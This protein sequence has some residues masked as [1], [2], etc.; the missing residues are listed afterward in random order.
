[1]KFQ[2]ASFVASLLFITK[3]L[4]LPQTG[5]T[6]SAAPAESDLRCELSIPYYYVSKVLMN[7]FPNQVVVYTYV[8]SFGIFLVLT[9]LTRRTRTNIV[10]S[11]FFSHKYI[12]NDLFTIG[13]SGYR[14]CGPI[15][16]VYG[17]L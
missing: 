4:A 5:G 13:P 15:E 3:V 10:R 17:G 12:Y 6:S 8:F 7:N 2:I 9:D 11:I 14:C 1:M 16:A